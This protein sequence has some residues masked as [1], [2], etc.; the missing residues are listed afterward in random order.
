[1]RWLTILLLSVAVATGQQLSI[2]VSNGASFIN[3]GSAAPGSLVG[4]RLLPQ[5]GQGIPLIDPA[6]V[7]VT[8]Q[9]GGAPYAMEC[10]VLPMNSGLGNFVG[11]GQVIALL[12]ANIDTGPAQLNFYY[13]GFKASEQIEILPA[14]FGLFTISQGFGPAL[15]QQVTSDHTVAKNQLTHPAKPG[16]YVVL[17][18]TG[19]GS[20]TQDEVTVML[21]GKPASVTWAGHAPGEPGVDTINFVVPDDASIPDE[22]YV[23]VWVEI[24]GVKSNAASISKTSDGSACQ[25]SLGLTAADLNMLDLTNAAQ[26]A[27]L[28]VSAVIASASGDFERIESAVFAAQLVTAP[29]IAQISGAVLADDAFFGCSVSPSAPSAIGAVLSIPTFIDFGNKVTLHRSAASVDLTS[30]GAVQIISDG[31]VQ[32]VH[33]S[34]SSGQ[35]SAAVSDPSLLAAPLFAPGTWMFSGGP[36]SSFMGFPTGAPFSQ[37]LTLPPEIAATNFSALQTINRQQDQMVTWNPAE[38]GD[39]DAV[40]VTLN[41]NS[42]GGRTFGGRTTITCRAPASAG[43]VAIPTTLLQFLAPGK[44]TAPGGAV[45]ELSATRRTG[46]TQ[47]FTLPLADGTSLPAVF[48]FSSSEFWPVSVQ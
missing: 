17:Y 36:G 13:N 48:R 22:C 4:I 24:A 34:Y 33:L 26:L 9:P 21:G 12:P 44:P 40:T 30:P 15:A 43:Q 45:I 5:P 16:D 47:T 14:S 20:V 11:L 39:H 46:P 19:L 31:N 28:T 1:M 6:T 23:A 7:Y 18:G 41:G 2:S 42:Y 27:Q 10:A 35:T 25:S 37:Q 38:F 3:A 8:L 32:L 29:V